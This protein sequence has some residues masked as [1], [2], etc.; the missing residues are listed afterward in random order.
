[1]IITIIVIIPHHT[2]YGYFHDQDIARKPLEN[3]I[4]I[5]ILFLAVGNFK[6]LKAAREFKAMVVQE[7]AWI[8]GLFHPESSPVAGF[9]LAE[10]LKTKT[11]PMCK[12]Q[13]FWGWKSCGCKTL[14]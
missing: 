9:A 6:W 10:F 7:G 12:Q 3:K 1:M 13:P 11:V 2:G 14:P 5:Q 4:N 8:R